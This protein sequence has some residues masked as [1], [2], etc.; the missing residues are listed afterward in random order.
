MKRNANTIEIWSR[1]KMLTSM[2]A[3]ISLFGLQV[4][5]DIERYAIGLARRNLKTS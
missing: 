3:K 4:K 1:G 5:C 2:W